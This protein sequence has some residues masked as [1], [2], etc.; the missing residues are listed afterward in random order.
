MHEVNNMEVKGTQLGCLFRIAT[1]VA[2]PSHPIG[3]ITK[4]MD[5]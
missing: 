1:I 2:Y 4:L 5:P 3:E